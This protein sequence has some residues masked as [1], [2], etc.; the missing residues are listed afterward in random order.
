MSVKIKK[1]AIDSSLPTVYFHCSNCT[2]PFLCIVLNKTK[3]GTIKDSL[4]MLVNNFTN[5]VPFFH[6]ML[7]YKVTGQ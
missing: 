2:G 3:K 4:F 1:S 5:S 7:M 6:F